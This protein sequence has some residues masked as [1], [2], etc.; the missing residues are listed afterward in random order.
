MR[1]LELARLDAM[2][3]SISEMV[4]SG[5]LDAIAPALRISERR[6][7]LLGLDRREVPLSVKL[8]KL[9][10][11][12]DALAVVA[13]LLVKAANGELLPEEAGKLSGL[14][15]TFGKVAET[16]DLQKRM[17]AVEGKLNEELARPVITH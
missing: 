2:L 6:G 17:E 13:T 4:L 16:V 7:R 8:P 3:E 14:V 5:A 1:T 15:Q 11:P 12:E 10:K 9:E